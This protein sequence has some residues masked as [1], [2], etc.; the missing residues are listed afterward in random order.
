MK[1]QDMTHRQHIPFG[2]VS[3]VPQVSVRTTLTGAY[4]RVRLCQKGPP[5][6]RDFRIESWAREIIQLATDDL[7]PGKPEQ[8]TRAGT[9]L[10]VIA[11]VVRDQDQAQ[12]DDRRSPETAIR[13]LWVRFPRASERMEAVESERL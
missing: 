1:D 13:V 11:I 9:G 2:R 5:E 7:F 4:L 10:A 8:F 6:L 3:H 12:Q